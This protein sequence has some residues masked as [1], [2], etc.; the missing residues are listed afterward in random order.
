MTHGRNAPTGWAA[1]R[2]F[3]QTP[4]PVFVH[5]HGNWRHG[6]YAK[7]GRVDRL[8]LRLAIAVLNGCWTGPLPW[9][10]EPAPGWAVFRT[11]RSAWPPN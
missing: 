8:H 10:R 1:F 9:H 7:Q 5:R 4:A 2:A 11:S 3:R 6:Y